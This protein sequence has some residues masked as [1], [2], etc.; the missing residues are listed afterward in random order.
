MNIIEFL[1]NGSGIH[2]KP[3]KRGSFTRWC[4]GNV[5][6]ECIRK[7]KNSPNTAIRKKATFADNARHF[8]HKKGGKAFVNGVNVLDSNP[9]AYKYVKKKVKMRQQGG[10]I[11]Q[12]IIWINN[13]PS[14]TDANRIFKH[15]NSIQQQ[16]DEYNNQKQQELKEINEE[17]QRY[18]S[19]LNEGINYL[20]KYLNKPKTIN[21][22]YS[23]TTLE[24]KL[25][26]SNGNQ[27]KGGMLNT[28]SKTFFNL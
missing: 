14:I 22:T 26:Y 5:T 10:L 28:D 18:S 15:N 21:S 12:E 16:T 20:F 11:P 24:P 4:G 27:F 17:A 7:G 3:S 2:I 25:V 6:E 8:K 9:D 1:K 19:F 23:N 13:N